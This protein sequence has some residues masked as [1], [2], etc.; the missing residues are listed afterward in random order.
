MK[1][2][3]IVKPGKVS[4]RL[5]KLA[6]AA[7]LIANK[8]RHAVGGYRTPRP[9]GASQIARAVKYDFDVVDGWMDCLKCYGGGEVDLSGRRVL[10]LGPGAD[11]G[12]GLILLAMGAASY[13]AVDVHNLAADA[14]AEFY[15]QLF[16][17][18]AARGHLDADIDS[19]RSE[20]ALAQGGAGER[21][22]YHCSRDFDLS[23]VA[24]DSI[25]LV[26]SQAAFEHFDDAVRTIGQ[27]SKSACP[28][29]LL[30]CEID[31]STHTR[32]I[33]SRDPLNVYRFSDAFYN[34]LKF[35]GSPNRVRPRA[36]REALVDAGWG[37]I[38]L[39]PLAVLDDSYLAKVQLSLAARFTAETNEMEYLSIT[40]CAKKNKPGIV[41]C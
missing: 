6:G 11:L 10:E 26:V 25:D 3:K 2:P 40:L 9:F 1:S 33:R 29:A 12:T 13:T 28:G 23:V 14:S 41:T 39:F 8:I 17:E 34:M 16:D 7:I 30:V 5:N 18:I 22:R 27:M 38:E 15:E 36:Y 21:L 37:D 4:N 24:D 31:L 32:W 19:L 20:L 35:S